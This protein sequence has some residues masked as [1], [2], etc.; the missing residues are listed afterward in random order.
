[1]GAS[2]GRKTGLVAKASKP[3]PTPA[4]KPTKK[5]AAKKADASERLRRE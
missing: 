5:K 1:M 2:K 3:K 4:R